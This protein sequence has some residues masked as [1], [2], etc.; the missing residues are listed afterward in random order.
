[1]EA[2]A[3]RHVDSIDKEKC[4]RILQDIEANALP[5]FRTDP[6]DPDQ[7]NTLATAVFTL[8]N[9]GVEGVVYGMEDFAHPVKTH[10]V[11]A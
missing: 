10:I 9:K 7:E 11:L 1:M 8:S 3:A 2:L 4:F 5:V 6:N